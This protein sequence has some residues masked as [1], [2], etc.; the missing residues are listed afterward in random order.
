MGQSNLQSNSSIREKRLKIN[1]LLVSV[2]AVAISLSM[3]SAFAQEVTI[4]DKRETPISTSDANAGS[5]A[6]IIVGAEGEIEV[7]SGTSVTVDSNNTV[8]IDGRIDNQAVSNGIG[9][10]FQTE[11]GETLM[12]GLDGNG[13][14]TVGA[15]DDNDNAGEN[16]YGVLID[17]DGTFEGNITIETNGN[18]GVRGDNSAGVSLQTEMVGNI[19]VDEILVQSDNNNGIEI[20]GELT[21]D[22]EVN[23]R[24]SAGR[25]GSHG[26]YVGENM[27]GQVR[28]LG[29]VSSGTDISRD[30]QFN[31]VPAVASIASIRISADLTGGIANDIVFRDQDGNIDNIAE[32]ASTAGYSQNNATIDASGG[33]LAILITPEKTSDTGWT[34]I[35][36]GNTESFYGDYS[37]MNQ[38]TIEVGGRNT[39]QDATAILITG[40]SQ[41]GTDYTT[42]LDFGIYNGLWGEMRSETLDAD[43]TVLRIGEGASVPE[44]VN[45]GNFESVVT[46]AVNTGGEYT[47]EGGDAF[48]IV[49]DEG[50]ALPRFEN[51]GTFIV[52]AGGENHSAVG[53]VDHSGTLTSFTNTG[54]FIARNAANVSTRTAVDLSAN[55]SGV[56]FFNSGIMIGDVHLGSGDNDITIEGLSLEGVA[57]A[58][59]L[60]IDAGLTPEEYTPLL[61]RGIDGILYV[62]AGSNTLD[63]T[64]NAELKGGIVSPNGDLAITLSDQ[65]Q[66][67]VNTDLGLNVT[68]MDIMDQSAVNIN[69]ASVDGFVSGINASGT[70]EFSAESNL[71][72]AVSGIVFDEET[73]NIVSAD[74]LIIDPDAN[75]QNQGSN[76]FVYDLTTEHVDDSINLIV[77]RRTSEQLGLSD[78]FGNIYEASLEVFGTDDGVASYLGGIESEE[79]FNTFYKSAMPI[80]FSQATYQA[81]KN[82]NNISLG[83]VSAQMDSLRR[84]IK[85]APPS[86][87]RNGVW[88]QEFAGIYDSQATAHER[89]ADTF[90]FGLSAGYEF[91]VSE[92]GVIGA[93]LSYNIGDIK[94]HGEPED[95]LAIQNTQ[96][97]LYSAFWMENFFIENQASIGYLDFSGDRYVMLDGEERLANS[98]WNGLQ[99]SG[100]IKAGYDLDMGSLTITPTAALNYNNIKQDEYTEVGG[101]TAI[102]LMVSEH[103]R[104]SMTTDLKLE[105]AHHTEFYG[106]DGLESTMSIVAQGG[107]S[108]QMKDDPIE[109]TA[110][111][112]SGTDYFTLYGDPFEK[113]SFQAG[114]GVFF[115]ANYF[116]FSIRYDAEWRDQYL[117]H[118][119][120]M[121]LR[122][123]F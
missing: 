54:S 17:G 41:G 86:Q 45:N 24:I 3:Q 91:A 117:G 29:F 79:D 66:I 70:V 90:N 14:I 77:R 100:L 111:F 57:N 16:N 72:I 92:R 116:A 61:G 89:G 11:T 74:T 118:S 8:T 67:T 34:D 46:A 38:R 37:L 39:G 63:L 33:G 97:G 73:F 19:V 105:V 56:T 113:N 35:T 23:D 95:R 109:M 102:N 78:T 15:L 2:S 6:D 87:V 27:D 64:G 55:T 81:V 53:I 103:T 106:E 58:T 80:N 43:A 47:G 21:G 71:D 36:I 114:L 59:Q 82:A 65:S 88:I 12:S 123:R 1:A 84:M 93:A 51:N 5:A 68:D 98:D 94:F 44:F 52:E 101:G 20:L 4:D 85:T 18:I 40:A 26:I 30:A 10:H 60:Y 69:V 96:I 75:I 120:N 76:S 49:I 108:Q 7:T 83:A 28:N 50:G 115:S 99:Y 42:T 119:A 110:K 9:V 107:W 25:T 48:G 121:N 112:A 62:G 22:I 122:A 13:T 32:G 104:S 31:E